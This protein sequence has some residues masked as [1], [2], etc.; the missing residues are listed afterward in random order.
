MSTNVGI[1]DFLSAAA[2]A[3]IIGVTDVTVQRWAKAG[4]IAAAK[5]PGRTGAYLIARDEVQRA[6]A[7]HTARKA[8]A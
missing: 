2:A 7:A 5:L 3:R 4:R 1:A 8:A 6:A